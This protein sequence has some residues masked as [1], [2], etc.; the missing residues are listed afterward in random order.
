MKRTLFFKIFG[1]YIL[2]ILSISSLFLLFSFKSIR[3]NQIN[4]LKDDLENIALSME[5]RILQFLKDGNY[6]ELD[7]FVKRLGKNID[8]RITI[9]NPDG[10]V[11]A[12]SKKDPKSMENHATRPEIL[13]A[14]Y[15]KTGS[16]LRYSTTVKKEMLYVAIPV[17]EEGELIG[18][19]RVSLFLEQIKI[20][21]N[22]IRLNIVWAILII[23]FLSLFGAFLF[24]KSL[25]R[26]IKELVSA[27]NK[28]A[29]GD[30]DVRV[31]LRNRDELQ[32]LAQGF[33]NMVE[34]IKM[35]INN[36]SEQKEAINAII[37][38][39]HEGLLVLD[40][41]GKILMSNKSFKDISGIENIE[42]K[43][44]WEVIRDPE[45]GELIRNVE[46]EK[47]GIIKEIELLDKNYICNATYLNE[48][49]EIVLTFI[50]I[51]EMK[52]VERI[53]KDFVVN[54][55]HELRTPLTAIKGF[56]ETLEESVN[57][58]NR[59][60]VEIVLRHTERLINIVKDLLALSE[61]EESR[62][63]LEIEDVDLEKLLKSVF[64]IYE[65][66]IKNKKLKFIFESEKKLPIIK[67]DSYRLEQ[68]FI[69]LLENSIKYT[70]KGEIK[71]TLKS[72]NKKVKLEVKDTGIG[73]A[74]EHLP[75]IFERFYVVDKSRSRKL[76]GTGLGLSIVKHIVLL[77]K[78]NID[79]KSNP[80]EGTSFIITLPVSV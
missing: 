39:I 60:Y 73:I 80:G 58:K 75:R 16:S 50:N 3:E 8:T 14:L 45:L 67:G 59:R 43:L 35:L 62:I 49:E 71:V 33:N 61:L 15:G 40:K 31:Y 53:K 32:I 51:S 24:S 79:V 36:L 22:S 10:V 1:G 38:S 74:E 66:E 65:N 57:K 48:Y 64:T 46:K 5:S 72:E 56:M 28:V 76:G 63:K 19:L 47:A 27:S 4:L 18:V 34:R 11:L 41:N 12:D 37:T 21:L 6:D 55:S 13:N 25:S 26:P 9:I 29:D 52:G 44:Y 68:M 77:H 78:G 69:N 54:V 20:L 2:I 42:G 17:R 30:F 23:I 7:S 70:E